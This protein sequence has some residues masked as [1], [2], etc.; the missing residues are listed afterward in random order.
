M[1]TFRKTPATRF[2]CTKDI[3]KFQS[4]IEQRT[5]TDTDE[6]SP[7]KYSTLTI[8][9]SCLQ[10]FSALHTELPAFI[11]KYG[12]HVKKL[13]YFMDRR[14]P[15]CGKNLKQILRNMPNL[16]SITFFSTTWNAIPIKKA[17][18]ADF[19]DMVSLSEL[20]VLGH[21]NHP[22]LSEFTARFGS[23]IRRLHWGQRHNPHSAHISLQ[24]VA[25]KCVN[26]ETIKISNWSTD[27]VVPFLV[28]NAVTNAPLKHFSIRVTPFELK[29][30]GI[31]DFSDLSRIFEIVNS[32]AITLETICLHVD[33]TGLKLPEDASKITKFGSGLNF[34]KVQELSLLYAVVGHPFFKVCLQACPELK[35]LIFLDTKQVLK[36][37]NDKVNIDKLVE[38][39]RRLWSL[40]TGT[41][42]YKIFIQS[43]RFDEKVG[44]QLPYIFEV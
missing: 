21:E 32:F 29:D 7:F 36:N 23:Q 38:V 41:K 40:V 42:V 13:L 26:L 3:E 22:F 5:P 30:S 8:D 18:F 4:E 31:T 16:K 17:Y 37:I 34:P 35:Y 44:K 1:V 9:W 10:D 33:P 43:C 24:R 12:H 28:T 20:E 11:L 15:T 27:L 39:S 2:L 25:E 6:P 19:F 14:V